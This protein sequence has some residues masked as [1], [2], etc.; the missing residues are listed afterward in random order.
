VG[1]GATVIQ[2]VCESAVVSAGAVVGPF[3]H[4]TPGTTIDGAQG[5]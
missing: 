1:A 5:Q 4:L 2:S 3:A